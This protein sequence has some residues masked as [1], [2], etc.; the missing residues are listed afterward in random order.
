VSVAK[1]VQGWIDP[2]NIDG[3][4]EAV[5][6]E[7]I[8]RFVSQP[9]AESAYWMADRAKGHVLIML[10]WVDDEA[11][12]R[13]R[14][15]DGA[16]R[17]LM[18]ERVGLRVTAVQTMEVVGVHEMAA[19]TSPVS[20]WARATWVEGV[21]PD[22][23]VDISALHR[24]TVPDQML[25]EGFCGSYWLSS[26]GSGN[27]LA[28]SFWE[29]PGHLADSGRG[30]RRR[31]RKVEE[32]LRCRVNLVSAYEALGG[33]RTARTVEVDVDVPLDRG[34]ALAVGD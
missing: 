31:R 4:A 34:A 17:A 13:S 33:V 1:I 10:I 18:A 30:S 32:A 9:G 5:E 11:V 7:L 19:T 8:P 24:D 16:T 26:P 28:L 22:I 27:G 29:Q 12:R 2:N 21:D 6:T 25:S 14:S 3:A 23:D 15:A 20:R